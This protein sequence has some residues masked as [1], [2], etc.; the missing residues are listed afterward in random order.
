MHITVVARDQLELRDRNQL[1]A[2]NTAVYPPGKNADSPERQV[3]WAP[4]EVSVMARMDPEG[5]IVAHAGVLVRDGLLDDVPVRIGGIG[6]VK[7]HPALRARQLGRAVMAR[8]AELLRDDLEVDFGLLVCPAGVIGFYERLGWKVFHGTLLAEQ[9]DGRIEF[10]LNQPMVLPARLDP[11]S[12][13]V[14]D[15]QGLPW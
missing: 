8:A 1:A 6:G 10:T 3:T 7:S 5:D 15:L 14:I 12:T 2:L 13:G 4:T 11:P 9:P